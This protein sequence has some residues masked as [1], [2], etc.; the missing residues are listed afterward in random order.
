[1]K[2]ATN[3]LASFIS[4]LNIGSEEM[5]IE[6]YVQLARKEIVNA[7]YNMVELV[8]LAWGKEVHLGLHLNEEP[9]EGNRVDD[10][11]TPIVKLPQTREYAQLG[12]LYT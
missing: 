4:S 10:Q 7:K 12:P 8:D 1:M 3:N 9:M 6:E 2:E 5:A 11:L